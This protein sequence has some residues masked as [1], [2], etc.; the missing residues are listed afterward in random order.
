[1]T[2]PE[3]ART[4]TGAPDTPGWRVR[5]VPNLYPLVGDRVP[6]AHEVVVLSPAHDATFGHLDDAAA[7]EVLAV[8]RDRS[9]HHLAGGLV[10]AQPFVNS[11]KAAGASIE[12][13][14]AQLVALGFV[15]PALDAMQRRFAEAGR[16]LVRDAIDAVDGEHC[17]ASGDGVTAWCSPTSLSP[18]EVLV[19]HEE[20]GAR[21]DTA[22]DG[23]IDACARMLRRVVVGVTGALGDVPYNVVVHTAARDTGARDFHWFVRVT[24]RVA[25]T[26]GFEAGT[27]VLVD[28]VPPEQAAA[29]LR[30][31]RV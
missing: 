11:G 12:H 3:V 26:A 21:F 22:P 2:P 30:E 28:T 16:D 23:E 15:P 5:V 20:S 13:P 29:Q 4:G 8:L 17:V 27:G 19:A 7:T 14:H 25:V 6:G 24:P 1:M 31:A 10:H 9:A 18:Y